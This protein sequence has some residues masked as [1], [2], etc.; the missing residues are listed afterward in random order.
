MNELK[1]T[2]NK[3]L[4][5]NVMVSPFVRKSLREHFSLSVEQ[6]ALQAEEGSMSVDDYYLYLKG[7][8][9]EERARQRR[10]EN[11][12]RNREYR[13]RERVKTYKNSVMEKLEDLVSKDTDQ[14]VISLKK[15]NN[16]LSGILE[17]LTTSSSLVI[18]GGGRIWTLNSRN[19]SIIT[20]LIE[21]AIFTEIVG[22]KKS[23]EELIDVIKNFDFITVYR[24][25][26][27]EPKDTTK[28]GTGAQGKRKNKA[29]VASFFRYYHNIEGYDF[30]RLQLFPCY[31]Q[32]QYDDNCF[33]WALRNFGLSTVEINTIKNKI[34]MRCFPA[35]DIQ[36]I[37]LSLGL[38]IDITRP[39]CKNVIG[40]GL[41]TLINTPRHIKLGLIDDHYFLHEPLKQEI[42]SYAIKTYD[43]DNKDPLWFKRSSHRG[44]GKGI[45]NTYKLMMC[46][47]KHKD[48]ALT[49]IPREDLLFTQFYDKN[50]NIDELNYIPEMCLM[51]NDQRMAKYVASIDRRKKELP[52]LNIFFDFETNTKFKTADK[53]YIH[54]AY[55]VCWM[56]EI[57]GKATPVEHA[58]GNNCAKEMFKFCAT[59]YGQDYKMTFIAHNCGYDY[60]F[61]REFSYNNKF[62]QNG[63]SLICGSGV[64]YDNQDR[65]VKINFKDS[66]KMISTGL[67]NFFKMFHLEVFKEYIPYA[68]YTT[69]NIE[70]VFV[71]ISDCQ[72]FIDT[73]EDD[74]TF[75]KNCIKWKCFNR[76]ETK[77]DILKYS[78]KYCELDCI[79]LQKGYSSFRESVREISSKSNKLGD[80]LG[81]PPINIDD[82]FT[83][84][85]VAIKIHELD[86]C[87]VGCNR[88]SGIPREFHQKCVVGGR[89]MTRENKKVIATARKITDPDHRHYGKTQY[90]DDF[91]SVSN[92]TS[93]M[94]RIEGFIKGAPKVI[95][96]LKYDDTEE[97]ITELNKLSNNSHYFLHVKVLKVGIHR[98]FPCISIQN[99]LTGV[100]DFTDYVE[101]EELY[102][103]KTMLNDWIKFHKIE[104]ALI[105]GYYYDEGYNNQVNIT[106]DT[107]FNKR[108]EEKKKGNPIQ[109]VYKL[110]LNSS[111]GKTLENAHE[112]ETKH[113][114]L[115]Q[116]DAYIE[117]NY[118]FIKS[119]KEIDDKTMEV[120]VY[121]PIDNHY[122]DVQ[123]GVSILSMSKRIMNE[124]MCLAEDKGLDC[125][126][127]DTD[128]IHMNSLDVPLLAVAFEKEYERVLIGKKLGQFHS[129][130]DMEGCKDVRSV[131]F[132]ALAK[133][134]Y[135]DTLEGINTTTGEKES[136]SHI[137]M[138]GVPNRSINC[139]ANQGN[140]SV[141]EMY[142]YLAGGQVGNYQHKK[143]D[144]EN[145]TVEIVELPQELKFNKA[146]EKEKPSFQGNKAV[147]NI[148]RKADGSD[149]LVFKFLDDWT[150]TNY[151]DHETKKGNTGFER[152][153][154]FNN[155]NLLEF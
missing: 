67:R 41:P 22:V 91:D 57:D 71:D 142:E 44:F 90:I 108:L 36:P 86:G 136:G 140:E 149:M 100:R 50:K 82:F 85:S 7:Q 151:N 1:E 56:A 102:C 30:S 73:A 135:Q 70:K 99:E 3:N 31:R 146:G 35:K 54:K 144:E 24:V 60:R 89:T 45:T 138:K 118:N 15:L 127:T 12:R 29:V 88:L 43:K 145:M 10:V 18:R 65:K 141:E 13:A 66:Y 32:G 96:P 92:Y 134:C 119:M 117:R 25:K 125:Y 98:Q 107:L 155:E 147:F 122:N 93:A 114:T 47:I 150:I 87:F 128:S 121:K 2:E 5:S 123:Q 77:I 64:I 130:F 103:D 68:L 76:K 72:D 38:Y 153:V 84:S 20:Q 49:L 63:H 8:R 28:Q 112:D 19:R 23:D 137:R 11:A 101:G 59:K 6:I 106:Q 14:V 39:D 33:V 34:T 83:I 105:R 61:C 17:V 129:D 42:T 131:K 152:C 115:N 27:T 16:D 79:V 110:I 55:L 46:L 104:V 37:A 126:Y 113:I 94:T 62:I 154:G 74:E 97:L 81:L 111:Y 58:I 78:L 26:P 53:K 80:E 148:C 116:V 40:Y 69:E 120:K 133:K 9:D 124:V 4:N 75:I 21:G 132:I 52:N 139:L 109:E 95:P 143:Y 51:D 48:K